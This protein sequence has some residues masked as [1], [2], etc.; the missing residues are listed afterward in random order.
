MEKVN[1][2]TLTVSSVF[3]NE[4]NIPSVYTC[5]GENINPPL[6]VNGIPLETETL[7]LIMEDPDTSRGTFDH[8]LVWNIEPDTQ[9]T[10]NSIPG[11]TGTNGAGKTG[12]HGPCPPS[13]SH[14]YFFNVYALDTRLDLEPGATKKEL[15]EA[16]DGHIL[17]EAT[18]MGYYGR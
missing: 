17:G 13:G 14:R 16:M 12:Y 7:A 11:I 5:D 15:K 18:V 8:W 3:E 6:K 4:G 10:E 1:T 2:G 9:I